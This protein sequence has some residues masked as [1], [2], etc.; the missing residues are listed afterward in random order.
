MSQVI[1]VRVS[2]TWIEGLGLS[3]IGVITE[4]ISV[5]TEFGSTSTPPIIDW[6]D[7]GTVNGHHGERVESPS[8]K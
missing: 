2:V 1:E 5:P 4:V 3:R 7:D 6:T 8:D